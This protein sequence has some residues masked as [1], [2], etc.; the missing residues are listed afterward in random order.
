MSTTQNAQPGKYAVAL[1]K[2]GSACYQGIWELFVYEY[3]KQIVVSK[4]NLVCAWFVLAR[5]K[6]TLAYRMDGGN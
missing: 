2:L 3:E 5:K 1:T 4:L 6:K